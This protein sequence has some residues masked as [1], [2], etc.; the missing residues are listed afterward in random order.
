LRI[1]ERAE[2]DTVTSI[3]NIAT[4]GVVTGDIEQSLLLLFGLVAFET[5]E[6]EKAI[7]LLEQVKLKDSTNFLALNMA[8]QD[9]YFQTGQKD[10]Q[11]A[12]LDH[13]LTVHPDYKFAL[14]NRSALL[15]Q[16]EDYIAALQ[17]LNTQ[18]ENSPADVSTLTRRG[19]ANL[20][21]ENLEEAWQDFQAVQKQNPNDSL[22]R[23]RL[24]DIREKKKEQ[25]EVKQEAN[26]QLRINPLDTK[27]LTDKANATKSLGEYREAVKAAEQAIKQDPKSVQA[28]ATLI[29]IYTAMNQPEKAAAIKKRMIGATSKSRVRREAPELRGLILRD[30]I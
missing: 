5:K 25:E 23:V 9:S 15:F 3:S 21:A 4:S 18:V 26:D 17:D 29:K 6:Y 20:K 27:A 10:K 28:Y 24:K 12:S 13:V 11:I 7:E 8:L 22:T 1:N 30:S 2:I 19:V 14:D 16:Q